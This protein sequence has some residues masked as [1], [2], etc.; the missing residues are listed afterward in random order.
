M[1]KD[2]VIDLR[3][4]TR[5]D[6]LSRIAVASLNCYEEGGIKPVRVLRSARH[7]GGD[8]FGGIL[9]VQT[10]NP[11]ARQARCL[12]RYNPAEGFGFGS[13]VF[14]KI[15]RARKYLATMEEK[16]TQ[17]DYQGLLKSLIR[18]KPTLR[19]RLTGHWTYADALSKE[20]RRRL[21][22]K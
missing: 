17:P 16:L 1:S 20:A 10:E 22:R 7:V 18:E 8:Q 15:E 2:M 9:C 21:Q 14:T 3:R 11:R 12:V 5:R 6:L 13:S 19:R 4:Y